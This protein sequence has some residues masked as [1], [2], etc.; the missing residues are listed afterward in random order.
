M[1]LIFDTETTGLPRNFNAPLTD[2]DNW[3]RMVQL[4]WQ[5]HDSK[6]HLIES[7]SIIVKPEGYTIPFGAVQIHHI[8]TEKALEH[9]IPLSEALNQFNSVLQKANYACGHNI[10][11]DKNIIGAEYL[12]LGLNDSVS[13][14]PVIDTAE[15]TTE[16]CQLPGGRGGK[17]KYPKLGELH[18]LLFNKDFAEAHN[19]GFDVE[20]NTR[21][22]FECFKRGI[23]TRPEAEIDPEISSYLAAK[24]SEITKELLVF[25]LESKSATETPIATKEI[26]KEEKSQIPFVHLRNHSQYSVLQSTTGVNDLVKI[27][28]K[29]NMPGIALTDSGNM[30]S[31]FKFWAAVDKQNKSI[32]SHNQDVES[33]KIN[34]EKKNLLKCI[35]GTEIYICRDHKNKSVQDN[36]Y[37]QPLIAKNKIGYQNLIKLSSIS[38][39]DGSYYVPRIDK[40]VLEKY[41]DGLITTTG[42]IFSEIPSLI[43]NVGET[44][45]EEVFCWYHQLFGEN[46]YIELN[47]HHTPEEDAVNEVLLR[48]AQKYNVKYFAANNNYYLEKKQSRAHDVLLCIKEGEKISTPVGKGRGFRH[49]LPNDEFYFKSPAEMAQLFSD[50]PEA[51]SNTIEICNS[52]ED[53]KLSRDVL[54]PKFDIPEEFKDPRDLDPNDEGKG[55]RGENNY[56]RHL[57]YVGAAKKYGD[58]LSDVVKER[59]DFELATVERMGFP[60]Y[61]LIVQDFTTEARKMGVAV[62][63]GRGSAAGS[64]IAYCLSITNVDPIKYDLLFE[65]FLNPERISMPDI[66]IDFDDEG[67]DKVIKYVIDKYGKDRVSQ[68]ITYGTLGGKSALRDAA[69]VLDLS[70]PDADKL[71]KTFPDHLSANLKGILGPG[72]ISKQFEDTFNAEQIQR[73]KEFRKISEGT[74]LEADTVNQAYEIEGC[75]RNIGVHACGVIITPDE[76]TKFVPVATAKDAEMVVSQFDNSVAESAGLLKMDFLGLKTLTQIKE[77]CRLIR[78]RHKIDI[79]PE[80]IPLDDEKAFKLFQEGGTNGIFQFESPGMQKYLKELKPDKFGDLIA[81]NALYRPGPLEYIPN[82][83]KRKHGVEEITYD[84]PGMEEYLADTYGITVYQEQVM[85]LS[86]KLAG[87]TKGEAD[88]LRKAMGKKQRDVLDKMKGKFIDGCKANN[89]DTV[90]AEKVWRDWEAFASYAFNKS[91]STCYALLAMQTGYLKANYPAEFMA[92]TL[93]HNMR[94][95]KDVSFFLEECRRIKIKVLGPDVN[96][97]EYHFTV[98]NNGEIRFGMGAIKGVGEGAVEAIVIERKANGPFTSIFDLCKRIDGKAANKKTLEGLAYGG[99]FDSFGVARRVYFHEE[100]EGNS[101][102]NKAIKYGNSMK[103]DVDSMQQSL[104]GEENTIEIQ[105]P[106]LP[107]LE[108]WPILQKLHLEKLVVGLFISGHPL[109]QFQR[110]L[111]NFIRYNVSDINDDKFKHIGKEMLLAGIVT[112]AEHRIAKNGNG[113]G[114]FEIEDYH[115]SAKFMV[116]GEDYLKYKHLMNENTY[117]LVKG[118]FEKRWEGENVEFKVKQMDMLENLRKNYT[119]SIE[120]VIDSHKVNTKMVDDLFDQLSKFKG[121]TPLKISLL[122]NLERM[123]IDLTSRQIMVDPSNELMDELENMKLEEVLLNG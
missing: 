18:S 79:D 35:I 120:L 95:I 122:D 60:G 33:G 9:G 84:L 116:F 112:K 91:H 34:E 69:R 99:G 96:E 83:I 15:E 65:R 57:T 87:F 76:L 72:G 77:A 55:N 49:G 5:L 113:F 27:A 21:C 64:I 20:A 102:L 51:L 108:E 53:F 14:M 63:P 25:E 67:R 26:S 39:V 85:L 46:F 50:L 115:G 117:V 97:S 103:D 100:S 68:I 82:Y 92:A 43:V 105:E 10:K 24:A 29:Y 121:K 90:K 4:A 16:F 6:G 101:I 42:S 47:R 71:A 2:S 36:G 73:A 114:T 28:A 54:L 7:K 110:D 89:L 93:T 70:L 30:Y 62:G 1:F 78:E 86:Q 81:M 31:A 13:P 59:I 17:F 109:N 40:G 22:L 48:W 12:R 58:P 19:A 8:S 52:I 41:I 106:V 66:D 98:N 94:D 118:K 107:Q 56:L 80:E 44:Q 88:T 11:F 104:F 111:K 23:I 75:V 74:N 38:Y 37:P 123:K 119:K 45:A 32:I 3:P 61:F